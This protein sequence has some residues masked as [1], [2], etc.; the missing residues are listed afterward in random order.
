[1]RALAYSSGDW[2]GLLTRDPVLRSGEAL[3][4]VMLL[5]EAAADAKDTIIDWQP[6]PEGCAC[7]L[8]CVTSCTCRASDICAPSV[9][10]PSH[11]AS[12]VI[13]GLA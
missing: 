9:K 3:D 7:F 4:C 11:I 8:N 2:R 12:P 13:R 6:E 1:M 10:N 5:L